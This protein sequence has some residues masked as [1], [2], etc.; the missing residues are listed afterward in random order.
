MQETSLHFII[1]LYK[2]LINM[3]YTVQRIQHRI[4]LI[5]TP[6]NALID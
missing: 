4:V 2:L 1:V 5:S 3:H 6:T